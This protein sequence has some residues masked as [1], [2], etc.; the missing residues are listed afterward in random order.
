MKSFFTHPSHLST[1]LACVRIITGAFIAYHGFEV[2]SPEKMKVYFE[3]DMFKSS[4]G[5]SMVYLG[6]GAEFLAGVMLILGIYTRVG[7]FILVAT[8]AYITFFVGN[9]K[10]WYHAQHPFMFVLLGLIYLF[11]GSVKWGVDSN[12]NH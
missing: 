9:G 11:A 10:I 12:I 8:M 1:V 4:I 3:W 5:P 2:F 6:K 7:A